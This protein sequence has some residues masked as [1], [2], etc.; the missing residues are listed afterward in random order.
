MNHYVYKI[1][2]NTGHFYFGSRSCE[3]LPEQDITYLGSPVTHRKYWE[4]HA[5]EKIIIRNFETREEACEHENVLIEWSWEVNKNLSLNAS[6]SGVKFN[7][8][9]LARDEAFKQRVSSIRQK[10]FQIS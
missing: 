4:L 2:F 7:T 9:G 6:I 8:L 3:C 1:K 10:T 5:P